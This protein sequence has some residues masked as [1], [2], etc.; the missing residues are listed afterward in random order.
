[1]TTSLNEQKVKWDEKAYLSFSQDE[2]LVVALALLQTEERK[3]SFEELVAQCFRLFPKK[4]ELQGYPQWPNAGIVNKSWLRC[5]SDKKFVRG[6][7]AEGFAL[8]PKG[9]EAAKK[10]FFRLSKFTGQT[11]NQDFQGR[12]ADKQTDSGRV[13]MHVEKS[14]AYQKYR[15]TKSLSGISEHEACDVLYALVESDAE[16]LKKNYE[17]VMQHVE[18]YGREDLISFLKNLRN[19]FVSRFISTKTAG[20]MLPQNQKASGG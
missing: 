1:M 17:A 2:L 10:I 8:T 11:I 9:V 12:K 18:S 20:G 19:K 5:R 13:V 15:D 6:N 7:V 3:V 16:T 14:S 4:F